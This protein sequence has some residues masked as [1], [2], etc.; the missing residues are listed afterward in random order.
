MQTRFYRH[1]KDKPYR[2]LGTVR[3]SETFEELTLYETLYENAHGKLWVRPKKMFFETIENEGKQIPRF[4]HVKF[5]F[6]GK[7]EVTEESFSS[8]HG[9]ARQCFPEFDLQKIRERLNGKENIFLQIAYDRDEP[10]AFKLGYAESATSFYSYLGA[11]LPGYRG[12]GLASI[13]M[14]NQHVWCVKNGFHFITTKSTNQFPDMIYL[15]L[16]NGFRICGV[17]KPVGN[18]NKE[19]DIL[20]QKT[21]KS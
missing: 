13:L 1:Y 16:Q 5:N 6:V 12:L 10:V 4:E 3:H 7:T 19:I 2:V 9:V 20:F 15:N 18:S 14:K 8:M 21:L 17:E 11:V